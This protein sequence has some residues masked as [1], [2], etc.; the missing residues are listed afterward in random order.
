MYKDGSL[1]ATAT[2]AKSGWFLLCANLTKGYSATA[3]MGGNSVTDYAAGGAE[4]CI[5]IFNVQSGKA[6]Q[7]TVQWRGTGGDFKQNST[8]VIAQ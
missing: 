7:L 3:L 6:Y 5:E 8:T 2:Y 1:K 4:K